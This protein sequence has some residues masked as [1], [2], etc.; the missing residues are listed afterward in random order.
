[1]EKERKQAAFLRPLAGFRPFVFA[2]VFFAALLP[3]L[4]MFFY[5]LSD[6]RRQAAAGAEEKALFVLR[7]ASR[8]QE[9]LVLNTVQTLSVLALLPEMHAPGPATCNNILK[10]LLGQSPWLANVGLLDLKGNLVCSA[11]PAQGPVNAA[12]RLYFRKVLRTGRPAV[13]EYAV[14]RTTG[15]PALHV[16]HPV[17]DERG[18]LRAVLWAALDLAWLANYSLGATLPPGMVFTLADKNG[19]ILVR[20]PDGEEW[21]GRR[22]E[23]LPL[24]EAAA[25]GGEGMRW[26][27][28]AKG[29]PQLTVFR[30]VA[31]PAEDAAIF[32]FV[33]ASNEAV[34]AAANTILLHGAAAAGLAGVSALAV[35]AFGGLAALFS[36]GRKKSSGSRRKNTGRFSKTPARPPSLS[37][38]TPPFPWPTPG[39]APSRDIPGRRSRGG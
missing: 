7:T 21:I 31:L 36:G 25:L 17:F 24:A 12:D 33:G 4:G 19:L 34:F 27:K 13:G 20:V 9:R 8:E 39:S 35:L 28:E 2:L 10:N 3:A 6:L 1:M 18:E 26:E 38:K 23:D 30:P 11:V 32:A 16:A 22:A 5:H 29:R 14:S 15:R 37:R